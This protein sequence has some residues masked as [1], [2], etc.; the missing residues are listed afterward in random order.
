MK[1]KN[2]I[3]TI[4]L[5]IS[6]IFLWMATLLDEI[7][8]FFENPPERYELYLLSIISVLYAIFFKEKKNNE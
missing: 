3:A 1:H 5:S 7:S 6:V 4:L 8:S 2:F